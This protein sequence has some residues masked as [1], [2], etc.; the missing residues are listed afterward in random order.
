MRKENMNEDWN[1]RKLR[2]EGE[3]RILKSLEK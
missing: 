3:K 1:K 2:Q